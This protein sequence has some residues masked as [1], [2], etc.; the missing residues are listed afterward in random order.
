MVT[1]A[2]DVSWLGDSNRVIGE[3]VWK[4]IP[5]PLAIVG[6]H[7]G[8]TPN[9]S[10]AGSL[11]GARAAGKKV[12][13]YIALTPGKTGAEHVAIGRTTAGGEWPWLRFVAIDCEVDGIT[14]QQIKDAMAAVA[15]AGGRPIIY[16]AYW[17]WY[18]HF[19]N[20]RDFWNVPLWDANYDGRHVLEPVGYGGFGKVVGHQYAGTGL[21]DTIHPDFNVFDTAWLAEQEGLTISPAM[22]TADLTQEYTDLYTAV[23]G[24]DHTSYPRL[25]NGHRQYLLELPR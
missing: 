14:V 20:K 11:Y 19:G 9:Y 22:S 8:V 5:Q 10:A 21:L 23:P 3:D 7:H 15:A 6:L 4:Q 16:T 17:W 25:A 13:G 12:A 2:V 18:S 1:E 24:V